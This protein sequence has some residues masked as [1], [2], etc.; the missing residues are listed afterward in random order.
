MPGHFHA[1]EAAALFVL[2]SHY[3]GS[4][5]DVKEFHGHAVTQVEGEFL[6]RFLALRRSDG[7]PKSPV[8]IT[9]VAAA[10]HS[11]A[12]GASVGLAFPSASTHDGESFGRKT[13]QEDLHAS[14][15][16]LHGKNFAGA[17]A[18]IGVGDRGNRNQT[19]FRVGDLLFIRIDRCGDDLLGDSRLV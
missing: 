16:T 18:R 12:R 9:A 14:P 19:V 11:A 10:E 4:R 13:G 6:G 15:E 2:S 5:F 1:F 3:E 8:F 7:C 17:A